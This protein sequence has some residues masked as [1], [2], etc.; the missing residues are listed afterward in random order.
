MHPTL[1]AI[2]RTRAAYMAQVNSMTHY[3]PNGATVFTLMSQQGYAF[4]DGGENIHFNSGFTE[5]Q[6]WQ[7]AM[8]EYLN[9]PSHRATMLKPN[10]RRN[11][12]A[13]STSAS[14]VRYY[15]IV[16]SD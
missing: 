6:S 11:G 7:T 2:A 8:T 10:L 1:M 3:G 4:V 13:V 12:A 5:S 9:S 14:G 16:F 15:S